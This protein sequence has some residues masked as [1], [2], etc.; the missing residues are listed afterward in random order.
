MSKM[1]RNSPTTILKSKIFRGVI[2]LYLSKKGKGQKGARKRGTDAPARMNGQ[3][4]RAVE[5]AENEPRTYGTP[6][7]NGVRKERIGV[8]RKTR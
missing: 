3:T 5:N 4:E 1:L 2:S 6:N 8:N 7:R